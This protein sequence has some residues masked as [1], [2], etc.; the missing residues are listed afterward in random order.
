M[1]KK[2]KNR[3]FYG[4]KNPTKSRHFPTKYETKIENSLRWRISNW[5]T[6][7]SGS[8]V[9]YALGM[10]LLQIGTC[11]Y[12]QDIDNLLFVCLRTFIK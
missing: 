9:F 6:D 2:P 5:K 7:D 1:V 10:F 3:P 8:D 11:D 12:A 4:K